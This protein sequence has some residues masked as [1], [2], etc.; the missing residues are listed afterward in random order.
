MSKVTNEDFVSAV[1]MEGTGYGLSG[2]FGEKTMKSLEDKELA[3]L[4]LAVSRAIRA[5]EDYV[6]DN[7]EEYLE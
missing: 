1:S 3:R 7:Y 6:E 5:Y 4:A 2:Y